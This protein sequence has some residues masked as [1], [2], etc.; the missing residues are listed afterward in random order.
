MTPTKASTAAPSVAGD[1]PS[2]VVQ[3][4]ALSA[5]K[6]HPSNP[7]RSV[8]DV[9]GLVASIAV[10]GILEPLIVAPFPA[11]VPT[12]QR[13]KAAHV[14]L[15][16]HRR[17][18]AAAKV[19]LT[20]VPVIVR[21]DLATLDVQIET[22]LTENLQR[23]DLSPV[24]EGDGYQLL[25]DLDGL[26][27]A[28]I[29][30]RL[31]QPVKRVKERLR[32]VPLPATVRDKLHTHQVTI[33]DA[34]AVG[35]FSNDPKRQGKLIKALGT[36]SWDWTLSSLRREAKAERALAAATKRVARTGTT[37]A[38]KK[39]RGVVE[40]A[41]LTFPADLNRPR[42]WSTSAEW[43]KWVKEHHAS[44][45]GSTAW[46]AHGE[47]VFGCATP[48]V[49]RTST[50]TEQ[51]RAAALAEGVDPDT[52]V[53]VDEE[54]AA[55]AA[56]RRA[57]QEARQEV[58]RQKAAARAT[59]T[60][61]RHAFLRELLGPGPGPDLAT[62]V[63][64]VVDLVLAKVPHYGPSPS[65]LMRLLAS[66]LQVELPGSGATRDDVVAVFEPALQRLDLPRLGLLLVVADHSTREANL[67]HPSLRIHE[68]EQVWL[69]IL[70]KL[71]KEWS[72]D[73]VDLYR[74]TAI[75][76]DDEL[77]QDV[78]ETWEPTG[79]V[80]RVPFDDEDDVDEVDE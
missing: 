60:E 26:T 61:L 41:D 73:E 44:C 78:R 37:V 51:A 39:P 80:S 21:D 5:L 58:D 43:E 24:E 29:A 68:F 36:G 10:A 46:T 54:A 55:A 57:D 14:V 69:A 11:E 34:L 30:D 79:M 48:E 40:L 33:A 76:F 19:K 59:G 52:G 49:H 62:L 7:R 74:W 64:L 27:H 63:P 16:G 25:L 71:G 3:L 2:P 4:V 65:T 56:A 17:L 72:P 28:Q 50:E 35:E 12:R 18:A 66:V 67:G 70:T 42:R 20:H 47:L 9:D 13:G 38:A 8:G 45:E 22:M 6:P 77:E 23:S 31:G 53:V 1:V 15:A 75:D 32:I